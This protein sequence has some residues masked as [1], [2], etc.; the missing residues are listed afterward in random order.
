MVTV[1]KA[2]I[3]F[4]AFSSSVLMCDSKPSGSFFVLNAMRPHIPD[5][6]CALSLVVGQPGGVA[7]TRKCKK[8]HVTVVVWA[9]SPN[10][11][12][13][14]LWTYWN[15]ETF[16]VFTPNRTS[17][18]FWN[19]AILCWGFVCP[20]C[21]LSHLCEWVGVNLGADVLW[22]HYNSQWAEVTRNNLVFPVS[23]F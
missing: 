5:R 3:S 4:P 20:C 7:N 21:L 17:P 18:P 19:P 16:W 14:A 2:S 6:L 10:R 9:N 13:E 12:P 22:S 8:Q 11:T 1:N 23:V 15:P